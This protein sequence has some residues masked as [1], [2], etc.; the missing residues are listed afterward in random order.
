MVKGASII[1]NEDAY[2]K[3]ML[4]RKLHEEDRSANEQDQ[5][6]QYAGTLMTT[7]LGV[8]WDGD[9]FD[10]IENFSSYATLADTLM[11]EY[12]PSMTRIVSDENGWQQIYLQ[13]VELQHDYQSVEELSAHA[14]SDNSLKLYV[15]EY[16]FTDNPETADMDYMVNYVG[17]KL[18]ESL[19]AY[20]NEYQEELANDLLGV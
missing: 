5:I 3:G 11:N 6:C 14:I 8:A 12:Y 20:I 13:N 4:N 7:D 19:D 10:D 17:G 18:F 1:M 2:F 15:K 16:L 9:S